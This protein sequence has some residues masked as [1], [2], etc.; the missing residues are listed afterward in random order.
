MTTREAPE[1]ML[2]EVAVSAPHR[3]MSS[4]TEI[5][6]SWVK[7]FDESNSSDIVRAQA[8]VGRVTQ[9]SD[10]F[11]DVSYPELY[12]IFHD[13][14]L[15]WHAVATK[16]IALAIEVITNFTR[17]TLLYISENNQHLV[18]TICEELVS[19]FFGNKDAELADQLLVLIQSYQDIDSYEERH[20][21]Q[22]MTWNNFHSKTPVQ[23]QMI[24][25]QQ[26]R[27][28]EQHNN[29]QHFPTAPPGRHD[30]V[31]YSHRQPLPNVTPGQHDQLSCSN[32]QPLPNAPPESHCNLELIAYWKV[33][34]CLYG[35]TLQTL[36]T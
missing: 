16:Y 12:G 22:K 13:L 21:R 11:S 19:T 6:E 33:C 31:P 35:L 28:Q 29:H 23:S 34:E 18:S 32:R 36:L 2:R 5:A 1:L 3:Q 20:Q 30:H 10:T 24:L 15:R 8:R 9:V 25:H 4:I 26:A 17:E 7:R 27:N 14:T